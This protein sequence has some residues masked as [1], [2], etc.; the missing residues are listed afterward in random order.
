MSEFGHFENNGNG[1]SEY[2]AARGEDKYS[3]GCGNA[4]CWTVALIG[5]IIFAILNAI[6]K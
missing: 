2:R 3:G 5:L 1:Y 6:A 4:G